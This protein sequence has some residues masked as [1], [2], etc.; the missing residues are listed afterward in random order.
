MIRSIIFDLDDTLFPEMEYIHSGFRK[1]SSFLSEN[2]K[3]NSKVIF[4]DLTGSNI[5]KEDKLLFTRLFKKLNIDRTLLKDCLDCY[6]SHKPDI[7]LSNDTESLLS[8]LKKRY[9][10]CL[11]TDGPPQIQRSKSIAL[12]LGRFF[13]IQIFTEIFGK[14]YRKPSVLPF[15]LAIKELEVCPS[16]CIYIGD[17]PLLDFSAPREIGIY[18]VRLQYPEQKHYMVES[19][20][21]LEPNETI[22]DIAAIQGIIRERSDF[23]II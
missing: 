16:E 10:L 9:D 11:I 6:R 7:R 12:G 4:D 21:G 19:E 3:I 1:V 13:K 5:F 22:W 20:Y 8:I 18:S 23:N 17:D 2:T 14:T 15:V